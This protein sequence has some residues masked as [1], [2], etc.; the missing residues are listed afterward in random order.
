MMSGKDFLKSHVLSWRRK[1]YSD[2]EDVTSSGR[3]YERTD[4]SMMP[5]YKDI[6][7]KQYDRLTKT[8]IY[9]NCLLLAEL[10]VCVVD[11]EDDGYWSSDT[12]DV[13]SWNATL[14]RCR[15]RHLSV[16]AILLISDSSIQ[17][18]YRS[19]LVIVKE[20]VTNT[21]TRLLF[22]RNCAFSDV[23]PNLFG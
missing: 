9:L 19:E 21:H 8:L 23:I 1:M 5:L 22:K 4:E 16:F 11:R 14:T 15:C 10:T 13:I 17:V 7:V 3:V 2:W 12:C 6:T 20:C 18:S